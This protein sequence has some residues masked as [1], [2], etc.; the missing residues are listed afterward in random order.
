M[1]IHARLHTLERTDAL[2]SWI[3]GIARRT[4]SHHFRA[5]RARMASV[6][7]LAAQ[8]TAELPPTPFD[9]TEQNDKVRELRCLLEQLDEPKREIFMMAHLDELTVPEI[10]EI[11]Q[12]PLNTAYSRLRAARYAFEAA[13][14][15][16]SEQCENG[17]G[18]CRT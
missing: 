14:E 18:T 3:Y 15:S 1:V 7:S 12:I 8:P 6:A 10:A 16:R 17:G 2:R 5:G 11:L 13:L 9:W 4:V